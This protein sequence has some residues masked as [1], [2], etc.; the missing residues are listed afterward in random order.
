MS[1]EFA[2]IYDQAK[3]KLNIRNETK[4]IHLWDQLSF[5]LGRQK[6]SDL[7]AASW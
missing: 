1:N 6:K 5:A 7:H 4:F 3:K 2:K